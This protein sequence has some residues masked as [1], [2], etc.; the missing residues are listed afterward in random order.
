M[1]FRTVSLS[2]IVSLGLSIPLFGGIIQLSPDDATDL[3]AAVSAA[4]DGDEI[5]L[6]AGDY[7]LSSEII[8]EK[9]VR[10]S[11]ADGVSRDSVVVTNATGSS[12]LF[13]M[14]NAGA[15]L[16]GLTL[17]GGVAEYGGAVLLRA[18]TVTNCVFSGNLTTGQYSQAVSASGGAVLMIANGGATV[19]D[20]HFHR[21]GALNGSAKLS[22]GAI[23][24]TAKVGS[25]SVV[26]CSFDG[27]SAYSGG[28]AYRVNLF[29]PQFISY[30]KEGDQRG[31]LLAC[32]CAVFRAVLPKISDR[33]M[34][35]I[36][37]KCDVYDT[38][39]SEIENKSGD[40]LQ[41]G[42]I[43]IYSG[44]LYNCTITRCRSQ[45]GYLTRDSNIYNSIVWGN[46]GKPELY[47]GTVMYSCL[48]SPREGGEN[49]LVDPLLAE[50]GQL[51][52]SPCLNA[53]MVDGAC[54]PEAAKR[55]VD[56]AGN[57][58]SALGGVDLGCF[59]RQT[60]TDGGVSVYIARAP[61]R[62]N[63]G[64]DV[65][66]EIAVVSLPGATVSLELD[67]GDG[68]TGLVT[69]EMSAYSEKAVVTHRYVRSGGFTVSVVASDGTETSE[70]AA[71]YVAQVADSATDLYVSSAGDDTQD[72][73]SAETAKATL[74][75][76]VMSAGSGA[77]IHL[78]PG[79]HAAGIDTLTLDKAVRIVGEDPR[80]T[81]FA[82]DGGLK[83]LVLNNPG[84]SV[85][86]IGFVGITNAMTVLTVSRGS[87]SR[88]RFESC[89]TVGVAMVS[90]ANVS[91][92]ALSDVVVTD[93]YAASLISGGSRDNVKVLDSK[94]LDS[95]GTNYGAAF[96]GVSF[97]RCRIE[98]VVADKCLTINCAA[99]D[100]FIAE[101]QA[102]GTAE[103]ILRNTSAYN[104]T[105]IN[106]RSKGSSA[107]VIA[108][109]YPHYNSIFYG[110]RNYD[111]KGNATV[112]GCFTENPTFYSCWIEEGTENCKDGDGKNVFGTDPV[113]GSDFH[114]RVASPCFDAGS[115]AS[116]YFPNAALRPVDLD[117][118]PR[119]RG[120]AIDLGCF[121]LDARGVVI[122]L[123]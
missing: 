49:I 84:L 16:S 44:A 18:G 2:W 112:M 106:N 3:A 104:C 50:D 118:K 73:R 43:L 107:T 38:F 32:E 40:G 122:I 121:E 116:A 28:A 30:R 123:R 113:L 114:L 102:A 13:T 60:L 46:V 117:G 53:A 27:N 119:V 26:R 22:G 69:R 120:A 103:G 48:E 93:C 115:S 64:E 82:A 98:R 86:G 75:Q 39:F 85:E 95:W 90:L 59:E 11:A 92:M 77:T 29:D 8:L 6:S 15:V 100:S 33:F 17:T 62:V 45:S 57:P 99:Y 35:G 97:Y 5:V 91:G 61:Q 101:N 74:Y 23:A 80:T 47:G 66:L 72:G 81:R 96:T 41:N 10:V 19:V 55:T 42:A 24:A 108:R 68:S 76:A 63:L 31:G 105:V 7:V 111:A 51:G 87:A 58:R 12:R 25:E 54:F 78:L 4:D 88:L 65:T 20:S 83:G 1:T 36:F 37:Y 34:G 14:D 67:F 56:A 9:A 70:D 52:I 21:N 79:D 71:P 109:N 94:V 89:R 110:N